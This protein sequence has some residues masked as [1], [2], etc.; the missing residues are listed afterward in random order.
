[1]RYFA[2]LYVGDGGKRLN[3][4]GVEQR[5]GAALSGIEPDNFNL[6]MLSAVIGVFRAAEIPVWV[7]ANPT[8][9]ENFR[10]VGAMDEEGLTAT[11]DTLAET[12]S[13]LGA[14]WIDVHD[15]FPD[16]HFRDA[17]GH[18][19]HSN[20][21]APPLLGEALAQALLESSPDS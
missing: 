20:P 13:A 6:S 17:A 4:L 12:V 9:V 5:F 3:Q 10:K 1:M 19:K 7:Y 15:L 18:F 14:H 16:D 8:N 11:L 2:D 21:D